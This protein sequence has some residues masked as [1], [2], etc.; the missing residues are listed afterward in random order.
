MENRPWSEWSSK[1]G[2]RLAV[3][4]QTFGI[5]SQRQYS[6]GDVRAYCSRDF[7][8]AW[9][10]YLSPMP[11]TAGRNEMLPLPEGKW[12]FRR[13]Q[14]SFL[15]CYLIDNGVVGGT[16]GICPSSFTIRVHSRN[17][18]LKNFVVN[19]GFYEHSSLHQWSCHLG[20]SN[21][22]AEIWGP[23][24]VAAGRSTGNGSPV[25]RQLSCHGLGGTQ[26]VQRRSIAA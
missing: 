25:S 6:S 5:E 16:G 14:K 22:R 9:E 20:G 7:Q 24:S 10:R 26:S 2:K 19:W 15:R 21:H 4:L 23:I 17:S 13:N 11:T 3:H 18:R 12:P 8:D 1:S